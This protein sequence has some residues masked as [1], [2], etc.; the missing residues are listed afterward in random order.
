MSQS[1]RLQHEDPIDSA[2]YTARC[3]DRASVLILSACGGSDETGAPAPGDGAEETPVTDGPAPAPTA[4]AAPE[5][6][7]N[8]GGER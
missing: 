7:E 5:P 1:W 6:A 4:D 8:S 3:P 2:S